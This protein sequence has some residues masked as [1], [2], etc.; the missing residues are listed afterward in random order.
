MTNQGQDKAVAKKC[1]HVAESPYP[2]TD[3]CHQI[4]TLHHWYFA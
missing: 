4:C 1:R 3:C 2:L